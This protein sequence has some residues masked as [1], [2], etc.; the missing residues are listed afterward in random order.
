[1]IKADIC[2]IGMNPAGLA[3]AAGAAALKASAVLVDIGEADGHGDLSPEVVAAAFVAAGKAADA[4]RHADRFGLRAR[5]PILEFDQVVAGIKARAALAAAANAPARYA[6]MGVR[7]LRSKARFTDKAILEAAGETVRARHF[8]V[9]ANAKARV[10]D[11]PGLGS[12]PCL[13][14]ATIQDM[15]RLPRRI[16]VIGASD[17]VLPLAQSLRRLGSLVDVF[18]AAP[19]LADWDA[20]LA[21]IALRALRQDGLVFHPATEIKRIELLPSETRLTAADASGERPFDVTH[22]LVA[23]E[24]AADVEQFNLEAAGVAVTPRGIAVDAVMR[25]PGNPRVYAVGASAAG[26]AGTLALAQHQAALVLRHAFFGGKG[27]PAPPPIRALFTDPELAWVGLAEAE[28]RAANAGPLTVLRLPLAEADRALAEAHGAGLIKVVA[29]ASGRILGCGIVGPHAAELIAP[30]ALALSRG[31]A[32]A[33]MAGLVLPGPSLSELTARVARM[34]YLPRLAKP[35]VSRL[36][37][38][39][40]WWG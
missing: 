29:S 38:L 3:V 5:E 24:S 22:L 17:G 6:A 1:M 25:C 36:L 33:D 7:V 14:P 27:A 26:G 2:I 30:W 40:R 34:W 10:P 16:A 15:P 13:T 19:A 37:R 21:G 18:G 4:V 8:V 23:A 20:E 12:V 31:L 39:T 11:I 9:A 35:G 28:A 32:V